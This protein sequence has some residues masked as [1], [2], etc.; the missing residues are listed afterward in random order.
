MVYLKKE[1]FSVGTY[2]KLQARK[3]DP[4]KIL[5]KINDNAY[6]VDLPSSTEIS[7]TFNVADLYAFYEDD[8]LYP[9]HNSGSSSSKAE[10]TNVEHMAKLI[11]GQ[12]DRFATSSWQKSPI[13]ASMGLKLIIGH[14]T[15]CFEKNGV[16]SVTHYFIVKYGL[17]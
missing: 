11:E 3:Y 1:R 15:Y 7:S 6:I 4:Y 2:H 17:F 13:C 12:L 14:I 5:K 8:L 16:T 10:G 9:E